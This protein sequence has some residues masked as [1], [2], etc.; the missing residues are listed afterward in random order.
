MPKSLKDNGLRK[1]ALGKEISCE[2]SL[3]LL[4]TLLINQFD[5]MVNKL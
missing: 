3:F 4:K 1:T 2:G 5:R